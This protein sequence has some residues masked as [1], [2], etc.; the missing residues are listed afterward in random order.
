MLVV[1]HGGWHEAGVVGG[2]WKH[3]SWA[4]PEPKGVGIRTSVKPGSWLIG[5]PTH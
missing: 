2:D 5:V 3:F 4:I 1:G